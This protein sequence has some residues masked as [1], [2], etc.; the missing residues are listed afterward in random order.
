MDPSLCGWTQSVS[1]LTDDISYFSFIHRR[2]IKPFL[3]FITHDAL[4]IDDP[5]NVQD[6]CHIRT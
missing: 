2:E 1:I 6:T 5:R 3:L 4:D